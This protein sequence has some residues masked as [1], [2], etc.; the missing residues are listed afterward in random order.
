MNPPKVS[1]NSGVFCRDCGTE[2][3]AIVGLGTKVQAQVEGF[4]LRQQKLFRV[5]LAGANNPLIAVV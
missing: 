5:F 1:D 4:K 3:V 2:S